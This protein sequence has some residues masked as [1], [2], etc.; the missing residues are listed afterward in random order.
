MTLGYLPEGH[1]CAPSTDLAQSEVSRRC[2]SLTRL[3]PW[4]SRGSPLGG[5][6]LPWPVSSAFW[7]ALLPGIQHQVTCLENTQKP[8]RRNRCA[9]RRENKG[10]FLQPENSLFS[11]L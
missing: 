4:N 5:A 1:H 10:S 6:A 8:Q 9:P 2:S 7:Q 11:H 3:R